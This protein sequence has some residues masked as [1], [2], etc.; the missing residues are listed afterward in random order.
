MYYLSFLKQLL[1]PDGA[2]IMT[3]SFN[4]RKQNV[5]CIFHAVGPRWNDVKFEILIF[6]G[7]QNEEKSL[8][9]CIENIIDLAFKKS[10]QISISTS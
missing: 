5:K 1:V 2:V 8:E 9:K 3:P 4:L 7:R 10:I 6:K